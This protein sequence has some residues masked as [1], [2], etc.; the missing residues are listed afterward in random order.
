M[1]W[2]DVVRSPVFLWS[3]SVCTASVTSPFISTVWCSRPCKPFS[4]SIKEKQVVEWDIPPELLKSPSLVYLGQNL[5]LHDCLHRWMPRGWLSF[6]KFQVVFIHISYSSIIRL[7]SGAETNMSLLFSL[8]STNESFLQEQTLGLV[9]HDIMTDTMV[10]ATW[11]HNRY[12]DSWY[13]ISPLICNFQ[14]GEV[15]QRSG[16]WRDLVFWSSCHL[17]SQQLE[18]LPLFLDWH[19]GLDLEMWTSLVKFI[20]KTRPAWKGWGCCTKAGRGL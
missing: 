10:H 16:W 17:L 5:L 18:G 3:L 19:L 12:Q 9:H 1:Y 6:W 15:S 13:M 14:L 4:V 8:I 20:L 11:H 2:E 7:V